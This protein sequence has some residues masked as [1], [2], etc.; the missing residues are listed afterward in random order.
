[1]FALR[2]LPAVAIR[3]RLMRWSALLVYVCVSCGFSAPIPSGKD[4]SRPFPCMHSRCGCQNAD[5]CWRSC[6]CHTA[7]E[8][9]AWASKHGVTPPDYVQQ[10]AT[11]AE[12]AQKSC[13]S[14]AKPA[15]KANAAK[16]SCCA[17]HAEHKCAQQRHTEPD[18]GVSFLQAMR[19]RGLSA[20][21]IG[22]A[23]S[24]TTDQLE[25]SI[26]FGV[27]EWLTSSPIVIPS[28]DLAPPI[29]PPRLATA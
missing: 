3:C 29:P 16:S 28:R 15:A 10:L 2:R 24:V 27:I 4:L 17:S 7:S 23:P 5:Q 19:C 25:C 12:P 20:N 6:C 26:S 21:W 13:C 1:M 18:R 9:L 22:M 14:S 11:Q 8:R